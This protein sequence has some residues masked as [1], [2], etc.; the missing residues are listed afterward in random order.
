MQALAGTAG[1]IELVQVARIQK[2][3]GKGPHIAGTVSNSSLSAPDGG[4]A[5]SGLVATEFWAVGRNSVLAREELLDAWMQFCGCLR[6]ANHKI[7]YSRLL[8]VGRD[9]A[10]T[11][12]TCARMCEREWTLIFTSA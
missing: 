12:F 8:R 5:M 4:A 3:G 1:P 6:M 9:V 11:F 2:S 7:A 10:P